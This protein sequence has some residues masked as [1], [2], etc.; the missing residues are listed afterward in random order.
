MY[1]N[2]ISITDYQWSLSHLLLIQLIHHSSRKIAELG[3]AGLRLWGALGP[4]VLWGPITH[5][6]H[7]NNHPSFNHPSNSKILKKW[8]SVYCI[9]CKLFYKR[10]YDRLTLTQIVIDEIMRI[11]WWQTDMI[12]LYVPDYVTTY[13]SSGAVLAQKFWGEGIAPI[14]PFL[15][16]SIFSIIRNQKFLKNFV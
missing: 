5:T 12:Y 8:L 2:D 4:N 3:R 1:W 14:S 13:V 10:T 15:T 9:V 16:E 7:C 11:M 6:I